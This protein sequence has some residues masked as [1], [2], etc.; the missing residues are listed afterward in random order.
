M[1]IVVVVV[2]VDVQVGEVIY[3]RVDVYVVLVVVVVVVRGEEARRSATR[4]KTGIVRRL[5]RRVR[6]TRVIYNIRCGYV[7]QIFLS[8][9]GRVRTWRR[10]V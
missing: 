1:V 9:R 8:H 4:V 6:V 10:V 3:N 2:V 7:R 5:W